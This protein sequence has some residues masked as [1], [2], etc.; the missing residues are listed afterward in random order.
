MKHKV[1][2]RNDETGKT[3][4]VENERLDPPGSYLSFKFTDEGLIIDHLSVEHE[5]LGTFGRMYDEITE[6]L[7]Q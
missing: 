1:T 6:T 2:T 7:I 3:V 4:F 5:V